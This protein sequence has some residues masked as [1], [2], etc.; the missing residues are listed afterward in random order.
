ML[1]A[2]LVAPLTA[3][4]QSLSL[5][6]DDEI[7]NDLKGFAV[8]IF[9]A[10]GL[11]AQDITIHIVQAKDVNAFVAA[12]QNMF[13]TTG[14]LLF[15]KNANQV[16]GVIAHE[17]GHISGGHLA[18]REE[19]LREAM[20]QQIV[21]VIL[22]AGAVVAGQPGAGQGI[23]LGG[24]Q[25]SERG[26]LAYSRGHEA[27]ADAAAVKYL[28]ASKQ[29]PRGIMEFLDMLGSRESRAAQQDEY[30]RSHPLTPDRVEYVREQLSQSPYA[31]A[32]PPQGDDEKFAR[33]QAK[34]I[35][36]LEP[37]SR[38]LRDY[39]E[40]DQSLAARY[41]RAIAYFRKPD[42][43]KALPLIDGLIAERPD[44]P[45]FWELKGQM[46]F[47]NGRLAESIPAYE[48]AVRLLPESYIIRA[49]LAKSYLETNN[50]TYIEPALANLHA[51]VG[52][53]RTIPELWR[54][55]AIAYGRKGDYPL[56]SLA[57]AERAFLV[58]DYKEANVQIARA[59]KGLPEYS[60][61]W[62]RAQDLRRAIKNAKSQ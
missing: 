21:S 4:A 36:F 28:E 13:F 1:S 42:L 48:E 15:A 12:G 61:G 49:G 33:I 54:L 14:L 26:F 50:P 32:P 55:L 38:T 10:A 43:N 7:E 31:D 60:A 20:M 52:Q 18:R 22:G 41:A 59:E 51:A 37:L 53:D 46:M 47:E 23:I 35:G 8:P 9:Q 3:S 11:E 2:A 34:L 27:S 17:A 45:Y 6:R 19:E 57:L 29:S 40:T 56:S 25:I 58:R 30:T 39:P 5:I 44:D 16:I 24:R 62:Q